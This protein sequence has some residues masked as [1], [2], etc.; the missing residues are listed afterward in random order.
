MQTSDPHFDLSGAAAAESLLTGT[1]PNGLAF[2]ANGDL[3]ISNFGTDRLE[4]MKRTGETV[5]ILEK[6]DGKPPG[7]I[8][9]C[10]IDKIGSG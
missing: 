8:L 7:S 4:R 6:L 9:F 2:A 5:V 1:L 3:L 10:A